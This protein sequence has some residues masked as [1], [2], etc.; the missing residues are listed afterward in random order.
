MSAFIRVNS[1]TV[2]SPCAITIRSHARLAAL[3][4]ATATS[5]VR[6]AGGEGLGG[7][8]FEG[9][10]SYGGILFQSRALVTADYFVAKRFRLFT[11]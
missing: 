6:S 7:S 8:C 9:F 1:S 11:P 5:S 2:R 4:L 3:N 10:M